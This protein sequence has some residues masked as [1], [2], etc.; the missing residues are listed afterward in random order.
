MVAQLASRV[1]MFVFCGD[2]AGSG[3]WRHA[4]ACDEHAVCSLAA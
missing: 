2:L 4:A 3:A 1:Q